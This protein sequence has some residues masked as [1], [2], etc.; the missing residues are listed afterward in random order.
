[1]FIGFILDSF[2]SADFDTNLAFAIV[3]ILIHTGIGVLLY[4]ARTE[5][6]DVMKHKSSFS[7]RQSGDIVYI[8]GKSSIS[9]NH[10][11]SNV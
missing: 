6:L 8:K 10:R 7:T 2:T 4:L 9:S 11:T 1:M 3:G 5:K